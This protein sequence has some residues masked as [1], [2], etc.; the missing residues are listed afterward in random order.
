MHIMKIPPNN[1]NYY[2]FHFLSEKSETQRLSDLA[3]NTQLEWSWGAK[4]LSSPGGG[5]YSGV[6]GRQVLG[7]GQPTGRH[8]KVWKS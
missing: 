6:H 4:W 2:R 7:C 1:P 5:T 3:K 8:R